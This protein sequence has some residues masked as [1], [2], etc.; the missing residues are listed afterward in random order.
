MSEVERARKLFRVYE[1]R[2]SSPSDRAAALN[3]LRGNGFRHMVE[4]GNPL[5]PV[6]DVH[7]H[8]SHRCECYD[9][10]GKRVR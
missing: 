6:C 9:A 2:T 10:N 8:L 7:E 5:V 3:W 1:S 4:P